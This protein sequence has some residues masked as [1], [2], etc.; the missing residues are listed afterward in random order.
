MG[1]GVS[2]SRAATREPAC[3]CDLAAPPVVL[4]AVLP[5]GL[6][7]REAVPPGM[8]SSHR[9]I[10]AMCCGTIGVS[11]SGNG[12]RVC[13]QWAPREAPIQESRDDLSLGMKEP[14]VPSPRQNDAISS[15]AARRHRLFNLL[16][17][18]QVVRSR[19]PPNNSRNRDDEP[20]G[21]PPRS[22]ISADVE[23]RG[24]HQI[25]Y[26]SPRGSSRAEVDQSTG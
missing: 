17:G 13:C 4:E 16:P 2:T 1:F 15:M 22:C 12:R 8:P 3:R 26:A 5:G 9:P 7:H 19:L 24:I 20:A 25:R 6:K 11:T 14:C 18:G 23:A 21:N 10:D